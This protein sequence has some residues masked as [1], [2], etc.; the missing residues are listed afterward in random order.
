MSTANPSTHTIKGEL[1]RNTQPTEGGVSGG[2]HYVVRDRENREMPI[3]LSPEMSRQVQ[4]GDIVEAQIDS[5]GQ[6]PSITK[7]Q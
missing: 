1:A 4:L 6:V 2:E 7:A 3:S 5:R